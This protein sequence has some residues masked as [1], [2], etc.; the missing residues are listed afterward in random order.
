MQL[1]TSPIVASLATFVFFLLAPLAGAETLSFQELPKKTGVA[2]H[3]GKSRQLHAA[4]EKGLYASRDNGRTWVLSYPFRLP[5]T[6][7]AATPDG[8]LYAFVAGKGLLRI[9][10]EEPLWSP[11]SNNLGSQVLT[12]SRVLPVIPPGCSG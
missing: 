4:T 10:G 11:V 12:S 8:S 9:R 7:V 3:D 5:A 6:M 1:K 2:L